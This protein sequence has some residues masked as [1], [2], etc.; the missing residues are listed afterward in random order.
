[1]RRFDEGEKDLK[2]AIALEP[3]NGELPYIL[4]NLYA[5]AGKGEEAIG[6]YDLALKI[7]PDF[8]DAAYNRGVVLLQLK[9]FKEALASQDLVL[10]QKAPARLIQMAL[11]ER[12]LNLA[13]LQNYRAVLEDLNRLLASDLVDVSA[14]LVRGQV[15]SDLANNL[16]GSEKDLDIVIRLAPK[17]PDGYRARG[18]T[19][20]RAEKWQG[21]VED[22][23]RYLAL[24][25][26]APDAEGIHNDISTAL[27]HLDKV[28]EAE[29]EFRLIKSVSSP[30][31]L[32][33]RG[34]LALKKGDLKSA[35]ADFDSAVRLDP[36]HTRAWALRGQ[37]KLRQGR[38]VEA[39]KDLDKALKLEPGVY[40]TL[41]FCGLA[42]YNRN[43]VATARDRL[44][45]VFQDRPQHVRGRMAHGILYMLDHEYAK[46][47]T[48]L[49]PA[50]HDEVLR[51]FALG[52][53]AQNWLAIGGTGL[54][55]AIADA[56]SY[57]KAL[58]RDGFA[59]LEAAR[60][61][62]LVARQADKTVAEQIRG[63]ALELLEVVRASHPDD[64]K[65][66]LRDAGFHDLYEMLSSKRTTENKKPR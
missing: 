38:L 16:E 37:A 25:P 62:S 41:L 8:A 30:S 36:D 40:E 45:V 6:Q 14:L 28:S 22:Y 26:D 48:E 11:Y 13:N 31:T 51:P 17:L 63:R 29:E 35:I 21:A 59:Q 1:L 27:L 19:R 2:K 4:G 15:V 5:A 10:A 52:L 23:R 56:E 7:K 3:K 32:T 57:A 58:P 50:V 55:E 53:R 46:A 44:K 12:A 66:L 49:T 34:N 39:A 54:S 9:R 18:L 43:N 42:H 60:I 61:L 33:N 47:L 20:F 65:D 64:L 24:R